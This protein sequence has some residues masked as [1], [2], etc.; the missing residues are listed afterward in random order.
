[1][2]PQRF[3]VTKAALLLAVLGMEGRAAGVSLESGYQI[4]QVLVKVVDVPISL[5]ADVGINLCSWAISNVAAIRED[6]RVSGGDEL[7]SVSDDL[8]MEC[9]TVTI[10]KLLHTWCIR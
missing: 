2:W 7:V 8:C 6:S 1:M 3:W 9:I 4:R 5:V 10:T